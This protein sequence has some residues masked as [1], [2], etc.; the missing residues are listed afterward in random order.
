MKLIIS[1]QLIFTFLVIHQSS[2]QFEKEIYLD[3]SELVT[4][5][6]SAIFKRVIAENE[7]QLLFKDYRVTDGTL[8]QD[9]QLSLDTI[10]G[11]LFVEQSIRFLKQGNCTSYYP[12][13]QKM[14]S[15]T[16]KDN[17]RA[18]KF[19]EWYSNGTLKGQYVYEQAEEGQYLS[20]FQP[21]LI[22][23]FYDSLGNQL[24]ADGFG[25]YIEVIKT[26]KERGSGPVEN[27]KKHG[28]WTGQYRYGFSIIKF[29]ETYYNGVLA[30][31][32]SQSTGG[33]LITYKK[34]NLPPEYK[35][36]IAKFYKFISKHVKYPKFARRNGIQGRVYVQ[37]VVDKEGKTT[38]VQVR[39]GI[40]PNCD[41]EALKAVEAADHFRPGLV[42]GRPVKTRMMMPVIF[43]LN[44]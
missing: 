7:S 9:G 13:G 34:M 20:D 1:L 44:N 35:G 10:S 19:Q 28:S 39:K 32:K 17:Q 25:T 14:R 5:S 29:E 18:G 38:D 2:G 42:R 12:N 43:N 3:E 37:F 27:G 36:G 26:N 41:Q 21:K 16:Y 31:G 30:I 40:G 6:T 8:Y 23:E 15:G 24:V 33:E 4:D 11:S 22:M